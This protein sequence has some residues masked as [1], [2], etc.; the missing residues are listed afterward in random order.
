MDNFTEADI[1]ALPSRTRVSGWF[2][3]IRIYALSLPV[4]P[5]R[6]GFLGRAENQV[7]LAARLLESEY[8]RTRAM[9]LWGLRNVAQ[10][11]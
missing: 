9:E 1:L 5:E 10:H 11:D 8:L 3:G 4:G 6:D 7:G 2:A